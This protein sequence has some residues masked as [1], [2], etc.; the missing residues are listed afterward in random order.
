LWPFSEWELI[1][2]MQHRADLFDQL[3]QDKDAAFL[4]ERVVAPIQAGK[5]AAAS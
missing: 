3:H 5:W 1:R 4:R 2:N